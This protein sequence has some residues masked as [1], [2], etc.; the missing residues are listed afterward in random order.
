MSATEDPEGCEHVGEKYVTYNR[1]KERRHRHEFPPFPPSLE[2]EE[3]AH[4]E[5]E[6]RAE[7]E[8]ER[9]VEMML[10]DR[11]ERPEGS[12]KAPVDRKTTFM[13]VI[14]YMLVSQQ[15]MSQS[16]AQVVDILARSCTLDTEV[17]HAAQGNSGAGSRP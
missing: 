17:P 7:C 6:R 16:L 11:Y 12:G 3:E 15:T 13:Q 4:R 2:E 5:E 9:E 14:N 1:H 8:A 10:G